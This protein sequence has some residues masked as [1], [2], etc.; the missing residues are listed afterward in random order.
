MVIN[1]FYR[2]VFL[3][4]L[5]KRQLQ[6]SSLL[7]VLSLNYLDFQ[8]SVAQESHNSFNHKMKIITAT[9]SKAV[10]QPT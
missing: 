7:I 10:N 8:L 3:R 5:S 9:L 6:W 2:F 4:Y 1:Y